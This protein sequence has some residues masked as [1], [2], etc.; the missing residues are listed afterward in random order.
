MNRKL[1]ILDVWWV[2]FHEKSPIKYF[3]EEISNL[4]ELYKNEI[5]NIFQLYKID[6]QIW[7]INDTIIFKKIWEVIKYDYNILLQDYLF[8]IWKKIDLE[9]L[10]FI[11]NNKDKYDFILATNTTEST[12]NYLCN[13]YLLNCIFVKIFA[14][15]E[16]WTRKP[17]IDFF[18]QISYYTINY[19][20]HIYLD[21]KKENIEQAKS[22]WINWR[23]FD[24]K[25][26]TINDFISFIE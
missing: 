2:I 23:V 25:H 12:I 17:D 16:M 18:Q 22:L 6:S 10:K 7:I 13:K 11:S 9:I 8:W 1:V 4:L 24:L 15:C 19:K 21:D 3:S 14:S 26:N 20:F 5:I